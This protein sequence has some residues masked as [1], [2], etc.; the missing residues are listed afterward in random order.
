MSREFGDR[1][2]EEKYGLDPIDPRV[3]QSQERISKA[4]DTVRSTPQGY[5]DRA[6]SVRGTEPTITALWAAV[7]VLQ[8]DV[9]ELQRELFQEGEE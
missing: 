5:V 2:I 7:N 9:A 4:Y 8:Q 1:E 6:G 3:R